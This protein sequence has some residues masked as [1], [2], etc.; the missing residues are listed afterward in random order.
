MIVAV[1]SSALAELARAQALEAE[2]RRE[3]A[4]RA[5]AELAELC[6]RSATG[7]RRRRSRRRR[8]GAATS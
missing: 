6:R 8:C 7:C 4:D 3:Q 2:R 1:V 5:L